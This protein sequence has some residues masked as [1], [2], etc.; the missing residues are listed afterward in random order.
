LIFPNG[1]HSRQ[2]PGWLGRPTLT[3]STI[4]QCRSAISKVIRQPSQRWFDLA[5]EHSG[6]FAGCRR[7]GGSLAGLGNATL[8]RAD[9]RGSAGENT[10]ESVKLVGIRP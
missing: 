5:H 9:L 10:C 7:S 6:N 1:D 8:H 4:P 2:R 3:L